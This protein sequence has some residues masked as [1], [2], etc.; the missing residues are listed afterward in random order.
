MGLLSTAAVLFSLAVAVAP[1]LVRLHQWYAAEFRGLNWAG[2]PPPLAALRRHPLR[3]LAPP[4]SSPG[5]PSSP[6]WR[7]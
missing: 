1:P 7:I 3:G 6:Q 2:A 4:P 5:S